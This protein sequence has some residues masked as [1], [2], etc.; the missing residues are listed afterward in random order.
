MIHTILEV[1]NIEQGELN[2]EG[3]VYTLTKTLTRV[4]SYT[5]PRVWSV[6][7]HTL[8]HQKFYKLLLAIIPRNFAYL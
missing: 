6:S 8:L 1:L 5:P 2:Q 7:L 3:D 4:Q